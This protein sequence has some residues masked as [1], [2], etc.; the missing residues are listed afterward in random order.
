MTLLQHYCAYQMLER[1]PQQ[2]SLTPSTCVATAP[3]IERLFSS[4]PKRRNLFLNFLERG[5]L[6]WFQYVNDRWMTYGW[7]ATPTSDAPI[8]L[9]NWMHQNSYWIFY[10]GTDGDFQGQG[11]F[12]RSL[13]IMVSDIFEINPAT[14]VNVETEA[15]N[16]PSRRAIISSG[17]S[18]SGMIDLLTIKLPYL[19]TQKWAGWN[20]NA[21]HPAMPTE[22][23]S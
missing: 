23:R 9:P 18:S 7:S 8:H 12:K 11:L 4:D 20:R 2:L 16:M 17:F 13:S 1:H 6:G 21:P 10:C 3:I 19:P 22:A 15:T 14:T 5:Y